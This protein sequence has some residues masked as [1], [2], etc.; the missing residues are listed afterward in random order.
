MANPYLDYY[1]AQAGSGLVGFQGVR[2]QRGHGFFGRLLTKAIY[3]L[4]KFFGKK[5]VGVG[6]DLATDIIVD[7]KNWKTAARERLNEAAEDVVKTGAKKAKSFAGSGKRRRKKRSIL[8]SGR[9]TIKR[10]TQRKLKNIKPKN[11]K[12]SLKNRKPIKKRK[13]KKKRKRKSKANFESLFT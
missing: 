9:K 12:V 3:P 11:N 7:K 13:T 4:I 2:Y 5:A 6:A 1:K 8:G 10:K